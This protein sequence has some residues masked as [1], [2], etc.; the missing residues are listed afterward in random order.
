[1]D[2]FAS[3]PLLTGGYTADIPEGKAVDSPAPLYFYPFF[4]QMEKE[5][6]LEQEKRINHF[7]TTEAG[8]F[9]HIT[10]KRGFFL[11]PLFSFLLST[12][13]TFLF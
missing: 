10:E 6:Y 5:T 2:N 9:I 7:L 8:A 4:S 13:S 11:S 3:I 12:T 1:M